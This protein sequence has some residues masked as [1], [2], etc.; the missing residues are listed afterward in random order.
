MTAC[1]GG[2]EDAPAPTTQPPTVEVAATSTPT[3]APPTATPVPPT[4]TPAPT[5]TPVVAPMAQDAS[6]STFPLPDDA[7]D[8]SYEMDEINFTSAAGVQDLAEFFRTALAADDWQELS[9]VTT[10]DDTLGFMEFDRGSESIYLTIFNLDSGSQ[11]SIDISDAP[12]LAGD[13]GGE[14]AGTGS[15]YTIADWPTP[16]DATEVDV[17]GDT[18][19]FKTALPLAEV[20]EFYRPTFEMM[21]LGTSCLDDAADYTSMSCS[22]G[23]GDITVNFF[24]F[25]G[26]D[27]TE[28][29][30]QFTNY[31]LGSPEDSGSAGTGELGVTDEDGL[32]LP[33][34]YTSYASEGGEFRRSI[35]ASSPSDLD[36]LT[37]FFQTELASRGWTLDNAEGTDTAATLR[38]SGDDGELTVD[39]QAGDETAI[40]MV[41]RNAAGAEEAGI[42][43]PAGQARVYLVSFADGDLTVSINGEEIVVPSGAGMESPDD[44]P[45]L[46]L[47][48][49]DYEVTTTVDGNSVTDQITLGA[50]EVWGLLLDQEGAL[51][52]QMY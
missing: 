48:P 11:A 23:N 20:A 9:D 51:P 37:E 30:I 24:A 29:E 14:M 21:E 46:D 38:F 27:N 36:T 3:S 12:S 7:Q 6:A 39:L 13:A 52:L 34:D 15:G 28:V 4:A 5:D 45:S 47:P 41:T 25:E 1:G 2:Q 40:S 33:D 35:E 26:F 22:Y 16:D 31:A 49:G 18:L 17:S 8:V 32:P 10:L 50:D 42:L 43:P 19:S 44:A